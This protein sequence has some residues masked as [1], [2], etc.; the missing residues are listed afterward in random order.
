MW[1]L[2]LIAGEE[3]YRSDDA[4]ALAAWLA[5]QRTRDAETAEHRAGLALTLVKSLGADVPE[6]YW[7]D[8][9][10]PPQRH[11]AKMPQSAYRQ[12]LAQAA[13]G[14]RPAETVLLLVLMAG[15]AAPAENEAGLLEDAISALRDDRP[16]SRGPVVG[17]GGGACL[18]TLTAN[19]EGA[20]GN[21]PV[22]GQF[23]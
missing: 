13:K 11:P 5:V 4:K 9:V 16:G 2:A 20:A 3:R 17:A 7:Q 8:L 1:V 12:A 23:S 6:R 15:S 18:R 10:Q 21:F 19:P 22:S 14:S